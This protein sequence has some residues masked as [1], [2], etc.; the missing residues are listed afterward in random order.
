LHLCRRLLVEDRNRASARALLER[1]PAA[2]GDRRLAY[3]WR[4]LV[5]AHRVSP[6]F[7]AVPSR[8]LERRSAGDSWA[9]AFCPDPEGRRAGLLPIRFRHPVGHHFAA[10][11]VELRKVPVC[12][13]GVAGRGGTRGR[14]T[15]HVAGAPAV[16]W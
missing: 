10:D 13:G 11:G 1:L 2:A 5:A 9:R 12:L 14:V 6:R 15:Y 4:V 7:P 8:R 16:A 3:C